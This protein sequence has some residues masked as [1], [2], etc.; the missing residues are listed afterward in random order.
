MSE[1][2]KKSEPAESEIRIDDLE[3]TEPTSEETE[4]LKGGLRGAGDQ[5]VKPGDQTFITEV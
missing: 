1:T 3:S 4:R 2:T 5:V